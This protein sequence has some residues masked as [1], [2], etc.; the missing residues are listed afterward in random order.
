M[1]K[2]IQRM[3][4][5]AKGCP[6]N[7]LHKYYLMNAE[8]E[9][10]SGDALKAMDLYDA[11]I[12]A[13]EKNG[14]I[15]HAAM[16]RELA[17]RFFQKK[18]GF[19]VQGSKLAEIYLR[20]ACSGYFHWGATAKVRALAEEFAFLRPEHGKETS[21][22]NG[23]DSEDM[24][25]LDAASIL[26]SAR[27]ISGELSLKNL[28]VKLM[29][30]ML[31]TAGAEEGCLLLAREG[32]LYIEAEGRIIKGEEDGHEKKGEDRFQILALES[33]PLVENGR[34]PA[35]I[36]NYVSRTLETVVLHDAAREGPFTGEPC[37]AGKG[38]RSILCLPILREAAL[39][40]VLYLE[41]NL[42]PG[43]FTGKK[44]EVL[45]HLARQAAI[46]L[47]NAMLYDQLGR[48]EE[49]QRQFSKKLVESQEAERKRIAAELH[50]SLAQNMM[51]ISAEALNA[52]REF[53][54]NGKEAELLNLIS[55][56]ALR[57]LR[58]IKEISYNLHPPQ[59]EQL[60]LKSAIRSLAKS[61]S[62]SFGLEIQEKIDV[63]KGTLFPWRG[64]SNIQNRPGGVEQYNQALEG[65]GRRGGDDPCK[66]LP[67]SEN[68]GQRQGV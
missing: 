61:V 32:T 27:I 23:K 34:R 7:F 57:S 30:V 63:K 66:R 48:S 58:E 52:V 37:V 19:K 54:I 64:D 55:A 49:A 15:H 10:V 68:N 21:E 24:D 29:E 5:W 17:G 31:E 12:D 9:R 3:K 33:L 8:R 51:A 40:G 22:A 38:L 65:Q 26:K 60:G 25:L 41:N 43:M 67:T 45:N 46:S 1:N 50:D 2:N 36:V 56:T 62:R 59:L 11:A 35:G 13:A 18:S 20:E 42:A 28:L 16:G 47:E 14:F 4:R 39:T 44:L 6:E 53:P